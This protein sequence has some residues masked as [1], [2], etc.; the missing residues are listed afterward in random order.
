MLKKEI[1]IINLSKNK[2]SNKILNNNK[3]ISLYIGP[4]CKK[5]INLTNENFDNTLNFYN[6]TNTRGYNQDIKL[7]KKNYFILLKLIT[8]I[9]NIAHDKKYKIR[10][11]EILV[12]RWLNT[13]INSVYFRWNYVNKI[14]NKY[15][16]N[17]LF[18]YKL[19]AQNFIP[20]DTEHAHR[21]HRG[22]GDWSELTF[23]QI[24]NYLH[25]KNL[26]KKYFLKK[27]IKE[28]K[29][30][31]IS[32]PRF[33]IFKNTSKLFLYK[34]EINI[35]TR[36][37]IRFQYNLYS[38]TFYS[39]KELVVD[40]K[41]NRK[42]LLNFL[43]KVSKKKFTNFLI[44]NLINNIPKIFLENFKDLENQYLRIKFPEKVKF[45]I[46]S[47][48]H[49]YD[50]FFKYCVALQINKNKDTKLCILQHGYGN[51][52]SKNDYFCSY[53]DQKISDMF[54]NWGK[55]KKNKKNI[56]FFYPRKNNYK[57]CK[58]KFLD[59]KKI[60]ILTYSFSNN[61]ISPPNGTL[62]G[63][64]INKKNL[65]NLKFL[66]DHSKKIIKDKIFIK[67]LKITEDDNF[68]D[69]LNQNFNFIKFENSK[70]SFIQ[71]EKKYS[72]FVHIFF[73]TPFFESLAL[74]RPSIIILSDHTHYP[75]DNKFKLL[76]S[77][78][79]QTNILFEDVELAT[80]F[81]N[82]NYFNLNKWWYEK[83]LQKVRKEFCEKYCLHVNNDIEI[84]KKI[85][86]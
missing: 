62:N 29:L 67:H 45:I 11:W 75:L 68:R 41:F 4:W 34:T 18:T 60:L 14:I 64:I 74:N 12:G 80:K 50:E 15:K 52:Y 9:L 37:K 47:Y 76:I 33:T 78:F 79:K 24:L 31:S 10:F 44:I 77:K 36:A 1:S 43:P 32:Y 5:K 17:N 51:I 63:E 6:A 19:K 82:K 57:I 7:L 30:I 81:I 27:K 54:L 8:K 70:K 25:K 83:K 61:L 28:N 53:H 73:G 66:L 71:V 65:L 48:G 35:K 39:L 49:Y 40:K 38:K 58:Y 72:L 85:F 16:I 84:F 23:E 55:V 69:Y 3:E 13:W 26:K 86:K 56:P 2:N 20:L 22:G 59:N 42:K 21:L 46:T